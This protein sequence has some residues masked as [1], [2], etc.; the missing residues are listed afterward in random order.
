M[1]VRIDT[2]VLRKEIFHYRRSLIFTYFLVFVLAVLFSSFPL[3]GALLK[4]RWNCINS[5]MEL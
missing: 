1:F 2:E 5:Y 3:G 4:P